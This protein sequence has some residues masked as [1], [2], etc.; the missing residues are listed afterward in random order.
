[1]GALKT[2]GYWASRTLA[3]TPGRQPAA[4]HCGLFRNSPPFPCAVVLVRCR[5][6]NLGHHK[7]GYLRKLAVITALFWGPKRLSFAWRCHR[8]RRLRLARKCLKLPIISTNILRNAYQAVPKFSTRGVLAQQDDV[9]PEVEMM[10]D[11]YHLVLPRVRPYLASLN[12]TNQP[13]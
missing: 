3:S 5:I 8:P 6:C 13:Q 12:S 4:P 9:V 7:V 2:S 1:M 10:G 11:L